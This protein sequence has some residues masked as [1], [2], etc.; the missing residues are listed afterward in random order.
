MI[1]DVIAIVAA[2]MSAATT[3]H[4]YAQGRDEAVVGGVFVFV[5]A[6]LTAIVL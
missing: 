6:T 5:L 2:A 4:A 3:V 1:V